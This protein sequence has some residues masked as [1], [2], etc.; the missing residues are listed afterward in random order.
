VFHRY[1]PRA[2][3]LAL[4]AASAVSTVLLAVV[5]PAQ[6]AP[7][8]ALGWSALVDTPSAYVPQTTCT[9]SPQPGTV[10]LA[11]WLQR[12]Y[13]G[14]GS[15]GIMRGCSVGGTSEHKDGR[16]FDWAADVAK[17]RT[18]KAAYDFITRALAT[19]AAGNPD[20]LARRL[21][22]MYF[23]YNDTIWAS[24]R[25]FAPR[26][27]LNAACP[28]KKNCSRTLRHL[29]HMHIS[30]GPAGAAAQTSWYRARNIASTPVLY[31]GTK[32]LDP[33]STAVTGLT[34]PSTAKLVTST[35]LLRAGVSYRLVATGTVAYASGAVGDA[36]CV[37]ADPA[38]TLTDRLLGSPS[39]PHPGGSSGDSG[40]PGDP[41]VGG[42]S[43]AELPTLT[44]HGLVLAG[45]LRWGDLCR[46]DHTYE[47]TYTPLID[48]QVQ[49]KYVDPVASDNTG[50]LS[51]YVARADI[52]A[53]SLARK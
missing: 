23:I 13:P 17:P 48:E 46:T 15:L 44:T 29:N 26:P 31:P 21:G 34:V 1:R 27:Y 5:I 18:R 52:T 53:A 2:R 10:A 12:I 14:T 4:L 11:R 39:G 38:W 40:I 47:A 50:T 51:V 25:D 9:K 7:V 24:Y 37:A 22:I 16:A 43:P 6:S 30:L 20:A 28:S 42:D 41:V 33:D 19:D 3:S 35:Y 36:N 45:A 49:L 8:A 32:E